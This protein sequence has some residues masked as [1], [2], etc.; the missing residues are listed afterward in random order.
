MANE[1]T[2][3][4]VTGRRELHFD[5]VDD[6]LADAERLA[7]GPYVQLGNWPLGTMCEHLAKA[8]NSA[9]DDNQYN[10]PWFFKL[11]GR[12]LK[13]GAITK[14]LSPGFRMPKKMEP[15]FMPSGDTSAEEGLAKLRE[16]IERFKVAKLP[17]RSTFLGKM[18]NDDWHQ[19]HCR[20]AEMHLSF[21]VPQ[22]EAN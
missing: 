11:L 4:K 21:L 16:A 12:M 15:I 3:T 13:K 6:I 19:F 20:H 22:S 7:S 9:T 2:T 5:S 18:S 14:S 10:P 1:V 17:E 8:L